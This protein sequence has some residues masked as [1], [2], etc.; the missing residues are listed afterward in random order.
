VTGALAPGKTSPDQVSAVAKACASLLEP[1][2][3]D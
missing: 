3:V 2:R 1:P